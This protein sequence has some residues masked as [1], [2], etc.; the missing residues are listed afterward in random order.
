M[1][2]SSTSGSLAAEWRRRRTIKCRRWMCRCDCGKTKIIRAAALRSGH[3]KSCG[4]TRKGKNSERMKTL[5]FIE[6]HLGK[7]AL[8]GISKAR[9]MDQTGAI[10]QHM[11]GKP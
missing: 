5:Y 4:C 7:D 3:I 11:M 1:K 6:R 9:E 8:A 10:L 2:R